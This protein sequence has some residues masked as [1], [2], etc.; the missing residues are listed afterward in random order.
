MSQHLCFVAPRA[1]TATASTLPASSMQRIRTISWTKLAAVSLFVAVLLGAQAV[2]AQMLTTSGAVTVAPQLQSLAGDGTNPPSTTPA[3]GLTQQ[4][5]PTDFVRDRAGNIYISDQ[6]NNTVEKLTPAGNLSIFAGGGSTVPTSAGPI[7]PL[8]AQFAAPQ[9]LAVDAAG[10]LYIADFGNNLIEEVSSNGQHLTVIAGG[11]AD[12][13]STT[14]DTPTSVQLVLPQSVAVDSAGNIYIADTVHFLVEEINASTGQLSVIAGG[15]APGSPGPSDFPPVSATSVYLGPPNG[16]ALD[17]FGNLYIASR[18]NGEILQLNLANQTIVVVA[19]PVEG[20]APATSTPSPAVFT[21]IPPPLNLA[22]NAAGDVF[23]ADGFDSTVLEWN[24]AT[25]QVF[26]F[27]TPSGVLPNIVDLADVQLDG[28]GNLYAADQGNNVLFEVT[29]NTTFP[30]TAVQ[31]AAARQTIDVQLT[32]DSALSSVTFPAAQLGSPEFGI[33][34]LAASGCVFDGVTINTSG[35]VCAI[36]VDFAPSEPGLR[37]GALTLSLTSGTPPI[38]TTVGTV[39][40]TGTGTAPQLAFSPGVISAIVGTGTPCSTSPSCGDGGSPGAAAL[41]SPNG[42]AIDNAGNI[43]IADTGDQLIREVSQSTGNI[44]TIAGNGSSTLTNNVS[45]LS[46]G[47]SSPTS[48]AVD[49]AGN[50]Y[51]A[52]FNNNVIRKVD[53]TTQIVTTVAGNGNPVYEGDGGLAIQASLNGPNAIAFGPDGNLYICDQSNNVIREYFPSD[54]SITTVAGNNATGGTIGGDGG[55]ALSAS[56]NFPN[57]V[58]VD[59]AGNIYIADTNSN[60]VREVTAATGIIN[61]YAGSYSSGSSGDGGLPTNAQLEAPA[62]LALDAAGNLYIGDYAANN[63]RV[64]TSDPRNPLIYTVAGAPAGFGAFAGDPGGDALFPQLSA[65]IDVAVDAAGNLY[66]ADAGNA[67]IRQVTVATTVTAG[68]PNTEP[69]VP[70]PSDEALLY[71]T[72]NERLVFA[73]PAAGTNPS[74]ANGFVFDTVDSTCPF[75][76]PLTRRTRNL[77]AGNSCLEVFEFQ[78]TLAGNYSGSIVFTD[79]ALNIPNSMQSI[80]LTGEGLVGST[81]TQLTF[82]TPPPALVTL[83]GGPG[84][85][86]VSITDAGGNIITTAS[87]SITLT[88]TDPNGHPVVGSPFGPFTTGSGQAGFDLAGLEL[89]TPGTYTYVATGGGAFTPA[90][91]LETVTGHNQPA[92]PE[93]VGVPNTQ[94]ETLTIGIPVAFTIGSIQMVTQGISNLD[95]TIDTHNRGTCRV[96]HAYIAGQ[97]CTVN[98]FFDP[99]APGLRLGA[100]RL[101]D[102]TA[103]TPVLEVTALTSGIGVG[104]LSAFIPGVI[105]NVAGSN[106]SGY[107][108]DGLT[109]TDPGTDL[110]VP[111]DAVTD[112]AGNLFIA[113]TA[114]SVVRRVDAV[115]RIITTIAGNNSL[116][117]GYTGDNGAATAAQLSA[118][119]GLAIDGNGTLYIS[120]TGNHAIRKVDPVTQIITTITGNGAP[121]TPGGPAPFCGDG[122]PAIF[123]QLNS[124][125]GISVSNS[126]N[127]LFIADTG[128]NVIREISSTTGLI[129]TVVGNGIAGYLPTDEN[130]PPATV[131]LN[132]PQGVTVDLSDGI[133]IA[134]TGNNRLRYAIAGQTSTITGNGTAGYAGDTLE[135][136]D[137]SIELNAPTRVAVDPLG[138]IY[139]SDSGNF[140]IRRADIQS[141]LLTT[142]VG[143]GVRGNSLDM[144][145]TSSSLGTPG[146]ISIDQA[147]NLFITDQTKSLIREVNV[148]ITPDLLFGF[149]PD[150]NIDG[151]ANIGYASIGTIPSVVSSIIV[152]PDF[153]LDTGTCITTVGSVLPPG[154]CNLAISFAPTEGAVF[155]STGSPASILTINTLNPVTNSALPAQTIGLNGIGVAGPPAGLTFVHPPANPLLMNPS[156]GQVSLGVV[157]AG[158][159]DANGF[160]I[161]T[162]SDTITLTITDPNGNPVFCDPTICTSIATVNGI[163]TF[164]LSAIVLFQQGTYIYTLTSS[165]G[166]AGNPCNSLSYEEAVV[167]SSL[168]TSAQVGQSSNGAGATIAITK[169]FTLGSISVV[170]TGLPNLDFTLDPNPGT[171]TVGVTY[172]PGDTCTVNYDFAPRAVGLRQGAILLYDQST[173][174]VVQASLLMVGLGHNGVPALTPGIIN[175]IAGNIGL[176]FGYSGDGGPATSAQLVAPQASVMDAAGNIYIADGGNNTIRRVDAATGDIS[177]I[178]GDPLHPGYHGDGGP[179]TAARFDFPVNISIDGPGNLYIA[180]ADNGVIRR[181]DSSGIITTVAGNF[182]ITAPNDGALATN[183]GL[184]EP[185]SARVDPTTGILYIADAGNNRIRA[186]DP[187]T[188]IITTVAGNG[189]PGFVGDPGPA[190]TAELN[191]PS[192]IAPVGG[193]NF[194]IAD[195]GN[196]RI[197]EVQ[198][199]GIS[200]VAGNGTAGYTGD[201]QGPTNAE[202]NDPLGITLDIAG[203]LYIADTGNFAIRR[204]SSGIIITVVGNGSGLPMQVPTDGVA[205]TASALGGPASVMLDGNANLYI[206]DYFNGLLSKVNVSVTPPLSFATTN[207]GSTSTDSPQGVGIINAGTDPILTPVLSPG[208][209]LPVNFTHDNT[210]FGS[211]PTPL[212]QLNPGAACNFEIDFMP[213]QGGTFSAT[214]TPPSVATYTVGN[215]TPS[216][217]LS[218]GLNG[219]GVSG[220]PAELAFINNTPPQLGFTGNSPGIVQTG[221]TDSNGFLVTTASDT[222][223]LNISGPTGF[224]FTPVTVATNA[225]GVAAFDLTALKFTIA[226]P[227]LYTIT[228]VNGYTQAIAFESVANGSFAVAAPV[229]I[230]IPVT[231]SG[232]QTVTVGFTTTGTLGAINVTT[233]GAAGLDFQLA[234]GNTCFIGTTYHAGQVCIVKFTFTPQA[235]GQRLGAI[236]LLDNSATPVLLSTVYLSGTGSGA[237]AALTPGIISTYAGD[238][239]LGAGYSGDNDPATSAQLDAPTGISVD[240][241]GNLYIADRNSQIIRKVDTSGN[242]TTVAG[243]IPG[244]GSFNGDGSPAV[245]AF[246]I[247]PNGTAVDGA[248]NLYIVDLSSET[249]RKVDVNT[250]LISTIAGGGVQVGVDI[251][252]GGPATSAFLFSPVG[253][254]VDAAGDL[255]IVDP[256]NQDV[257]RVDAV[258][259]IITTVAG[260]NRGPSAPPWGDGGSATSA[261]LS[262]PSAIALDAT[263]NLYIADTGLN[264]VRKVNAVTGIIT[265]YAGGGPDYGTPH[266]D[267][268]PATSAALVA[269]EALAVDAAGDL[270]IADGG[271]SLVRKVAAATGIISTVAGN[272][273]NGYQAS[274]DG[275]SATAAEIGISFGL[276]VDAS[277][278]LYMDDQPDQIIRKVNVTA[279]PD[280]T[281]PNTNAGL[282]STPASFTLSDIGTADLTT[283][284]TT[285]NSNFSVTATTPNTCPLGSSATT[286]IAAG[287]DCVYSVAFAPTTIGEFVGPNTIAAATSLPVFANV[288]I[289]FTDNALNAATQTIGLNGTAAI[290]LPTRLIFTTPPPAVTGTGTSP[291]LVAASIEDDFGDVVTTATDNISFTLAGPGGFFQTFNGSSTI[292]GALFDNFINT[293]LTQVGT[294]TLT[295][296]SSSGYISGVATI[297]TVPG[298]V[299]VSTPIVVTHPATASAVQTVTVGFNSTFTAGSITAVTQGVPSLDFNVVSGGTCAVGH[300]YNSGDTCTVS[301]TFSPTAPGQRLGAILVESNDATPILESSTLLSGTGTGA[302]AAF[303]PGIIHTIAGGSATATQFSGPQAVAVDAAGD[304]YIADT[305]AGGIIHKLD[306]LGDLTTIA[307][308]GSFGYAGDG[309]LA[310]D[311]SVIISYVGGIAL[312]GAGNLFFTDEYNGVVRRIDAV[313]GIITTVVGV[314]FNNSI[315]TTPPWGDNEPATSANINTP[316]GITVD[317]AGNLYIA[318][319]AHGLVRKVNPAGIITTVAGGGTPPD[320]IGDGLLATNAQF[321]DLIGVAVDA[322]GNLYITD[323]GNGEVREVN[324]S[325]GIVSSL[326][327]LSGPAGISLDP[328][329]NV[330]VTS[331]TI[332]QVYKISAGTGAVTSVAGNGAAGYLS[333]DEG[334]AATSAE[335]NLPL[336]VALDGAGNLYIAD[337]S[338]NLVRK[339]S[340]GVTVPLNFAT[341]QSGNSTAA[342]SFTLSNIGNAT[343]ATTSVTAPSD[344]EPVTVAPNTCPAT[345]AAGSI[346]AGVDCLYSIAFAPVTVSTYTSPSSAFTVADTLGTQTVGLNAIS[347]APSIFVTP[348]SIPTGA[349]AA[350]YSQQLDA[351]GGVAPYTFSATGLPAGLT[352]STSGLLSGTPTAGGN[353]AVNI[354]ATDS[355]TGPSAPYTGSQIDVLT[356]NQPVIVVPQTTLPTGTVAAVYTSSQFTASGGTA[357]YTYTA[358]G[359][360]AGLSLSTSGL[361]TGTPTAGGPFT[362]VV[363]ARDSS[364]G[365]GPYAGSSSFISLTINVPTIVVTQTTLPSGTVAA[366]YTQ[367]LSASGGTSTYSFTSTTL[368]SGLTLSSS[369]LLSGTPTAGG[370]FSITFTAHDSSTGTGPFTGQQTISLTINSPTI[371]IPQ[372]TLPAS[373]VAATYTSS[374]FAASGGTA[375]YTFTATGLPAGLSLS[376]A[377]LLTGTP[378]AG[379]VFSVVV[380]AHDSSTGTGPYTGASAT[381]SLSIAAATVTLTPTTTTLPLATGNVAYS[382]QFTAGGGTAPYQYTITSGALPTGITLNLNT[383]LLSGTSTVPE[384]TFNFTV[385]ATDSSTGTGPYTKSTAYSFHLNPAAPV[386]NS[387]STQ[388]LFNSTND[389]LPLSLTGGLAASVA[390]VTNPTHGSASASGTTITYT[391]T[392]GYIGPDTLTYTATNITSTSASALASIQ[393]GK[394]PVTITL[395]NLSPVYNAA[396]QI[397]TT[398]TVITSSSAPV[399]V[400]SITITYNGSS[401][402]PTL[403]GAYTVVATIVDNTYQ[404]TATS[405]MNIGEA[406]TGV[407]LAQTLPTTTGVGTGVATTFTAIVSGGSAGTPTGNV[408]FFDNGTSLGISP[409]T[410]GVATLTTTFTT[411]ATHPITAQYLSDGNFATNT[412]AIFNESVVTPNFSISSNPSA[413]TIEH[414]GSGTATL[415]FTP[416]GNYQGSL[417]LSCTGTPIFASCQFTPSTITF[418]GNNAVQTSQMVVFTLNAN[419]TTPPTTNGLLWIPAGLLACFIAIRRRKLSRTLRPVLML[420]LAAFA[421]AAMTGCGTGAHFVTPTGTDIVTVTASATGTP[422]T[423]SSNTTQTATITITITP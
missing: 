107:S 252:D 300:T 181:I 13:P 230:T 49:A 208:L 205:A 219:T 330:Y 251:G 99:T 250:G 73:D 41:A 56:L 339:V 126:S 178:A 228:G 236:Q 335:L 241:L 418:T 386:A 292:L 239:A 412:S 316:F 121:C 173:P 348:F 352:L 387:F 392:N 31:T 272:E 149:V 351:T 401:T 122:G 184:N 369:G 329:G 405:T 183:A 11:G 368:P 112:A 378:T 28:N 317:A 268:G 92:Q 202:L 402:P 229:P 224:T 135:V 216:T 253:I 190:L 420:V 246:L 347:T 380:T 282:V 95:F 233:E 54:G 341:T 264:S 302:L 415:T 217:V 148:S 7:A 1:K 88:V 161:S 179:A 211:C 146:S 65:P 234:S 116:G 194:Y 362:I 296:I 22:V 27:T 125:N 265:T 50:V 33:F 382:Q 269:P 374:Q 367:Q 403:A 102:T 307:G 72:G 245:G 188:G 197:R 109:A 337:S 137:P 324:A 421:L 158:V 357:P 20:S 323:Q 42:V 139:F 383:G 118:P 301:F 310:T 199:G 299:N 256:G 214:G 305:P 3:P 363:T 355:T 59:A 103:P 365:T 340:V 100:V 267:G 258:T 101:F 17:N 344:F 74:I 174:A 177:T 136:D 124:P 389:V 278:N 4:I 32:A 131:E 130:Q 66:I 257:R 84:G 343:L 198:N 104:P 128:D 396:P 391:P 144:T 67:V 36:P 399:T 39:G 200:T 113:D 60:V 379:G 2:S 313:S 209:V 147:G 423:S 284:A 86:I 26:T 171:C 167:L 57:G 406:P 204:I 19:G 46:T 63:I 407:S 315:Y 279:T 314:P 18:N 210:L 14:P 276:A 201:G 370:V 105:S 227:Y 297:T 142:L 64:V 328:A 398:T 388:V 85:V 106:S 411:V 69:G 52:D 321:S 159:A 195:S 285:I 71:N 295:A 62:G 12:A 311:P 304:V 89:T 48:V 400:A 37:T 189:T 332:T 283:S 326:A 164:D 244:S 91:F 271:H 417:T 364:T 185:S 5:I 43:Y 247:T 170:T 96:G 376:S 319:L 129:K 336:G 213:I 30:P 287:T 419:N 404:G 254:A 94:P 114:N 87:D 40:L 349:I 141:G 132:A 108:G 220:S 263:G 306:T 191:D 24:H 157:T 353:F 143:N 360:P 16:I 395:G 309:V 51:Y 98:Y 237:L 354:T 410:A 119:N 6:K 97:T 273:H 182:N 266:G 111:G 249:V 115:T 393:V 162:G 145:D 166:C 222:I 327:S 325:T 322:A 15:A 45:A 35:T 242:I 203:D 413:L 196:N 359:L 155:S 127:D 394:I 206:T 186:V 225:Q 371:V 350:P 25:Q 308:N 416:V 207:D 291:G 260:G 187:D 76:T 274:D 385:T 346:L 361:L 168:S 375:P 414:G 226:G 81:A 172:H 93:A 83:D 333:T 9:G 212:T 277:G 80:S 270:Y 248:G 165:N 53:A 180:D 221:V 10:D 288:E 134:D 262:V 55:S 8:T 298:S 373:I 21:T 255:Y 259:G 152:P 366:T 79:N 358:I 312:D 275:G 384:A 156:S 289:A 342:Q 34:S 390:I 293:T 318:D 163:A 331:T 117:A 240:E 151:P 320:G 381:I 223:T 154:I 123:G 176:G 70:V 175:T 82:T 160:F 422:G 38:T 169:T 47:I 138:D 232:V 231:S 77:A 133:V 192:D 68:F 58:A 408:Q 120:D 215:Q 110:N 290:G 280:L 193:G 218:I 281:L 29:P 397:A 294:Y 286:T 238:N 61:L 409:M 356:I 372:T 345:S 243:S 23:S 44:T 235:P 303:T 261:Y 90:T 153:T 75:A 78:P 150:G 140:V 338:N 334:A 377:G